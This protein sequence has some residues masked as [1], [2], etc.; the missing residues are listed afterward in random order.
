MAQSRT[1]AKDPMAELQ[2]QLSAQ[3]ESQQGTHTETSDAPGSKALVA[4]PFAREACN[5]PWDRVAQDPAS[6]QQS[7][8]PAQQNRWPSATH[9]DLKGLMDAAS[10]QFA[11]QGR[12]LEEPV[13]LPGQHA[14][15]HQEEKEVARLPQDAATASASDVAVQQCSEPQRM[16][17]GPFTG[18]G[19]DNMGGPWSHPWGPASSGVDP[20]KPP[21]SGWSHFMQN[22]G[23]KGDTQAPPVDDA[24]VG[25]LSNFFRA[26]NSQQKLGDSDWQAQL[27]SL[28]SASRGAQELTHQ[29]RGLQG[30]SLGQA[31]STNPDLYSKQATVTGI[32]QWL[33]STGELPEPQLDKP[34]QNPYQA[35]L[36][37]DFN[38]Q[39][40]NNMLAHAPEPVL[41]SW[42]QTS[43]QGSGVW[44]APANQPPPASSSKPCAS[45]SHHSLRHM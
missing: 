32:S 40:G 34:S 23:P 7:P 13:Q 35:S 22:L 29:N 38:R 21:G 1:E 24:Q 44:G 3:N 6:R 20:P 17:W 27:A 4:S 37:Q 8:A 42:L 12:Q 31:P 45:C 18:L 14:T 36:F 5:T 11:N 10:E 16:D 25:N 19:S 43:S 33:G 2:K 26:T 41:P 30:N 39:S 15:Q 28:Q 9:S